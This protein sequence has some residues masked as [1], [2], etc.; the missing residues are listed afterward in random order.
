MIFPQYGL[1]PIRIVVL[2]LGRV[3]Y[4]GSAQSLSADELWSLMASGVPTVTDE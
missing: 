4:D 3:A 2:S 1:W